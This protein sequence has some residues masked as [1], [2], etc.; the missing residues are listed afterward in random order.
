M[1]QVIV[2]YVSSPLQA[3]T[4]MVRD[5]QYHSI[6]TKQLQVLLGYAE[7]DIHDYS[8]QATAFSL[9][10]VRLQLCSVRKLRCVCIYFMCPWLR[11]YVL[12]FS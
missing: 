3:M 1:F 10:K 8:R 12:K 11:L 4:V 6:N 7:Q 2:P 5:I 9:L